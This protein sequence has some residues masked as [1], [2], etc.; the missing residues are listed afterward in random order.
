MTTISSE[1]KTIEIGRGLPTAMIGERINPTG[2]KKLAA[3]LQAGDF[4]Y[5]ARE[6]VRQVEAGATVID[7]NAGVPGIDEP[8]V[9]R[10]AVETVMR[11]VDVPLSIDSSDPDAL[12]A[13][14]SVYKG[15]A[16]VNSVTG[17]ERILAKVL[18]LVKKHGATVIGLT[19]DDSGISC[20][21]EDRVGIARRIVAAAEKYGIARED[22]LI[23]CLAMTVS[24]DHTAAQTTLAAIRRVTEELGVSTVLGASNVSYGLPDRVTINAIFLGMAIGAGLTS[25]IV[26]PTVPEIP[27][28]IVTADMLAG[29]DEYGMRYIQHYRATQQKG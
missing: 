1:S 22:L 4:D 25:A 12:E 7:V 26:D 18:P 13:A 17:E 14:L 24:A 15:K 2:K 21:A 29:R 6:A 10:Q 11:V 16:L 8:R 3:A 9:L 5:I 27:K 23:D 28:A 20:V 19:M